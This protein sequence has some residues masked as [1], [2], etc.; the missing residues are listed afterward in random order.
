MADFEGKA[1]LVE[2]VAS[3]AFSGA[4]LSNNGT[5]DL[6]GGGWTI[7]TCTSAALDDGVVGHVTMAAELRW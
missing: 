7:E 6:V 4:G 2:R 1:T 5:K 3:A